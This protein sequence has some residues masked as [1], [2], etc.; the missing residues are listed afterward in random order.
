M[1][2]DCAYSKLIPLEKLITHPRNNNR[3][4]IEQIETLAKLIEVH[5]FRKAIIVSNRSRYIV[6]GHGRKAAL[7]KLGWLEA[8]VEFQDFA[9]DEEEYQFLT[10]DNEIARWAE[11]DYQAVYDTIREM[12][13]IDSK[14][15]GIENF[16]LP[17]IILGEF[18]KGENKKDWEGMPEF[19]QD[20]KTS[21]R[22]LTVHFRNAED[23][24]DFFRLINQS[25]TGFTKSTWH[26]PQVNM[27]TESKRYDE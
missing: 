24:A 22:K 21:F 18:E 23:T 8:P 2:I 3:H 7:E 4:S 20:D 25:D 6:S 19:D 5:G 10:S 13:T 15:L 27:D 26:P 16:K 17:E 1:K 12:P 14:M 9:S 11:L